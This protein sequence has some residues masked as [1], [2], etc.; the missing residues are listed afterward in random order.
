MKTIEGHFADWESGVFGYGYGTGESPVLEVLQAFLRHTRD[1]SY[2]YRILEATL[3]PAVTWLLINALC[4]AD[5]IEYGT[6]PRFGWLTPQGLALRDFVCQR[7][8]DALEA[9]IDGHMEIICYRDHCN[10]SDGDCRPS[11]PFWY[12]IR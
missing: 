8:V 4:H 9:V 7:P 5:C 2:D 6:S 10:C 3:T 11:N 12:P 1:G